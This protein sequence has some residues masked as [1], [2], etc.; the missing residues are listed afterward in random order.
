[1]TQKLLSLTHTPQNYFR[2]NFTNDSCERRR[3]CRN[4]Q[5]VWWLNCQPHFQKVCAILPF[6]VN[7][8]WRIALWLIFYHCLLTTYS[9]FDWPRSRKMRKLCSSSVKT[10]RTILDMANLFERRAKSLTHHRYQSPNTFEQ[11]TFTRI[12]KY[13]VSANKPRNTP[14]IRLMFVV[15]VILIFRSIQNFIESTWTS[16]LSQIKKRVKQQ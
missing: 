15:C 14:K 7:T 1:M 3:Y 12:F 2:Y 6:T 4:F 9:W 16:F 5:I 8:Q 11:T 13:W 10:N